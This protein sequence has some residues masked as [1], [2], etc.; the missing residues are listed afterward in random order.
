MLP[1]SF[2][3]QFLGGDLLDIES[4]HGLAQVLGDLGDDG[5]V[6]VVGSGFYSVI[7]SI[8]APC[9]ARTPIFMLLSF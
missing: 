8:K 1:S 7:C 4:G 5:G 2:S 9:E 3:Q 6:L